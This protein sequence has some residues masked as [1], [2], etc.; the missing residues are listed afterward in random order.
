MK[1]YMASSNKGKIK[2]VESFFSQAEVIP[3]KNV[4]GFKEPEENGTT[5]KENSLIKAKALYNFIC[6]K[7]ED[8]D[9]VLADDSGII[10][11]ALGKDRLGVYTKRQM[12]A[13]TSKTGFTERDF[14][15]KIVDEAGE[16]EEALFTA[17]ISVIEKD[18][19]TSY[20]EAT[21]KGTLTYPSGNNGFGFDPIFMFEGK[22][23][24]GRTM[25]EKQMVNPRAKALKLV[26]IKF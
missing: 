20:Y 2:E 5:F 6:S 12:I 18:G 7:M 24:A 25:E 13:W 19:E 21:L 11:P 1:I 3:L 9:L 17:V 15:R 8:G 23:L 26:S 10:V 16:G 14:W 22:S 4:K